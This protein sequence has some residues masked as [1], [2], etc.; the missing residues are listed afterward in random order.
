MRIIFFFLVAIFVSG[1]KTPVRHTEN[2][3]SL[4]AGRNALI[5]PPVL[6]MNTVDVSWKKTRM[7]EHEANLCNLIRER[8]VLALKDKN[9]SAKILHAKDINDLSLQDPL[10][11][12]RDS[13]DPII[14]ELYNTELWDLKKA[15]VI[16]KSIKDDAAIFGKKT[17]SDLLVFVDCYRDI[18]TNGAHIRDQI[19]PWWISKAK[20]SAQYPDFSR[21]VVGFIDADTGKFIWSNISLYS[22]FKVSSDI[23]LAS[24][25]EY[26]GGIVDLVL[27]EFMREKKK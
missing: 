23:S 27:K 8:I 11:R 7:T 21:I 4:I 12:L 5:M 6:E 17:S 19:I 9:I 1:C 13:Y 26:A 15:A 16:D 25:F 10:R 20:G 14:K 3:Q 22:S 2:Y 24:G 18:K